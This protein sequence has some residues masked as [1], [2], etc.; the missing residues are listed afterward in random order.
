MGTPTGSTSGPADRRVHPLEGIHRQRI[1][2]TDIQ[3]TLLSYRLQP[4]EQWPDG[5]DNVI[6]WQTTTI[7]VQ[8]LTDVGLVGI[9]GC[10]RYAGPERVKEYVEGVIKPLLVGRNPF[11]V[12][13]LSAGIAGSGGRAA[14]AGV[15]VALWDIIGKACGLP[16]YRLLAIDGE[17]QPRLR[18][19]A[20]GGEFSWRRDSPFDGPES[21]VEKAV[22]HQRNGYTAFKFRMGGGFRRLGISLEDYIPYLYRMRAAVGPDFDLIQE[23]NCRWSVEQC[24][25]LCPVL[26]ELGFL[27]IEEPTSKG[28][29]DAI[30][31]YLRIKQALPT[32]MV[33][34]GEGRHNR[35]ELMEWV[36]RGAYDIVQHGCDDAGI[37]E[38]WHMARMTH[39][40][41]KHF[42]AHNWQGGL[43]TIANAHLMAAAPNRLMLES[44]MTPNPLK[45]LLFVETLAVSDGHLQIPEGPGLG[46]TVRDGL[47]EEYPYL[48]GPWNLPD[49]GMAGLR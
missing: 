27:W 33:S 9:G 3:V 42:C 31:N 19:Y 26:E 14:W 10:S 38:A 21:L 40:R 39:A 44:N 8:V 47:A 23:A 4:E 32:V 2:I 28:G 12:D 45:E 22:R 13:L 1:R 41:G 18:V 48:P 11:D 37:T 15:D 30:D 29:G 20:S 35:C 34:G 46:V 6:I 5:D 25:E 43:V 7:L 36:D 49:R 16:V 17:P 24:L